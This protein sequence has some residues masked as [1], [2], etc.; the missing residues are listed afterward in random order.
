M[1]KI[2]S[3]ESTEEIR[4]LVADDDKIFA[5]HLVDFLTN[6]GFYTRYARNGLEARNILLT[7]RPH[8][9]LIDLVLPEMNALQFLKHLGPNH[10]GED[11]IRVIIM[12]GHSHEANVRE[13]LRNGATDYI[14]KPLKYIDL[15][16]RLVLHSQKKRSVEDMGEVRSASQDSDSNY[17]LHLTDLIVRETLKPAVLNETLYNLTRMISL[18][19]KAVRVS[20]VHC[21]TG[22]SLGFVCGSSDLREINNLPIDLTKYPELIYVMTSGKV[23]ALDNLEKDPLMATVARQH[24]SITFNSLVVTPIF[25]PAPNDIWGVLSVRMPDSKSTLQDTEIRFLQLVGRV[26]SM[27][28]FKN[29][30]A[31]ASILVSARPTG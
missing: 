16:S 9:I 11:K 4:I 17:Y 18:A 25:Y 24:K 13:C 19:F 5:E 23:L 1:A 22:Q 27:T 10:V 21:D 30:A 29:P 6:N 14:I 28:L 31:A 3:N 8:F 26:I 12:S 15:L 20:V 7:W 2:V